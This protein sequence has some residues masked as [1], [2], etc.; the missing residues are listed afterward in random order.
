MR[1]NGRGAFQSFFGAGEMGFN[2]ESF[3]RDLRPT[4]TVGDIR[5]L[6]SRPAANVTTANL[7]LLTLC[8]KVLL[9]SNI[10]SSYVLLLFRF[11]LGSEKERNGATLSL[12]VGR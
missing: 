5:N 1:R 9:W 6:F 8:Q 4:F 10:C 2:F 11:D 7:R 12:S 3:N